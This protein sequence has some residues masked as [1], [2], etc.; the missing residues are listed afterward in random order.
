MMV[1][2]P[3]WDSHLPLMGTQ[4]MP[5]PFLVGTKSRA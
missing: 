5:A 1:M 3:F 4:G 2:P